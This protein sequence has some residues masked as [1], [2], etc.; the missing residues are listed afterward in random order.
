MDLQVTHRGVTYWNRTQKFLADA[1]Y[2]I[3]NGQMDKTHIKYPTYEIV[4]NRLLEA[5]SKKKL[6]VF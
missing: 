6:L 2:M 3:A 1:E 4:R 5:Y